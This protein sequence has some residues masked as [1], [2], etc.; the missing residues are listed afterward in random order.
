MPPDA[1]D[2]AHSYVAGPLQWPIHRDAF[3]LLTI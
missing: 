3:C 1:E 2:I